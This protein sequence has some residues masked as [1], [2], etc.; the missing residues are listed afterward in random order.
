MW[1]H[2]PLSALHELQE[3]DLASETTHECDSCG[4]Q[5]TG[6]TSKE[7]RA[8]GWQ[9]RSINS[10]NVYPSAF[11]MCGLC[12]KHYEPAWEQQGAQAKAA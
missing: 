9:W 12:I 10:T 11:V 7:L 6:Y 8:E 4:H 2:L 3:R 5:V 1:D